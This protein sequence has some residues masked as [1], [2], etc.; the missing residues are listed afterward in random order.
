[1]LSNCHEKFSQSQQ[2]SGKKKK[3]NGVIGKDSAGTL[4]AKE[5]H[6]MV[7]EV[8]AELRAALTT[9]ESSLGK[10]KTNHIIHIKE[11]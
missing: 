10:L 2:Q 3:N 6:T 9:C 8:I 11:N 1:M 5:K 4:T 7:V